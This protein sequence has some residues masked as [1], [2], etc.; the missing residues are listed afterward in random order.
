MDSRDDFQSQRYKLAASLILE[1]GCKYVADLASSGSALRELLPSVKYVACD[2]PEYDFEKP[3]HLPKQVDC[4]VAL[5][6]IE[7]VRNPRDFLHC[8]SSS[9]PRGGH[10]I[11][12]TPNAAFIKYRLQLLFG[13]TPEFCMGPSSKEV[14]FGKKYYSLSAKRKRELYFQLHVR[15]YTYR[16][17]RR[18]LELEGFKVRRLT[19][20]E[21]SFSGWL[22]RL[23]PADLQGPMFVVAE[24][25]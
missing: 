5:E 2:Y 10:L 9:L 24:K 21:D 8:V 12:S 23:L 3:F 17:M 15:G 19:Y 11:L 18:I 13:K 4:A 14:F 7:H 6:I 1:I 25:A 16:D 20:F 22:G